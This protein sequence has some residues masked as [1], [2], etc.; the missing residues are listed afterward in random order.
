MISLIFNRIVPATIVP[1]TI[2]LG[3]VRERAER[4]GFPIRT[5]LGGLMYWDICPNARSEI[6]SLTAAWHHQISDPT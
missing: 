1:G 4:R 5:T 6:P 3:S 2:V